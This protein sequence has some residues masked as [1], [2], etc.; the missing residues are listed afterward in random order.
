MTKQS[1]VGKY[2]YQK[3]TRKDKK[4]MTKVDGK[5]IHFG[6]KGMEHF[7]DKTGLLPKSKSHKDPKRRDNF[8]DRM[9]GIKTKSGSKAYKDPKQ[10]AYHAYNVLW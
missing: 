5:T 3:S 9:E 10:P 7:K 6:S 1:K 8:R 2:T 4:L